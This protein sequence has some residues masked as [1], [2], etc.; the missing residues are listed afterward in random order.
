M[1]KRKRIEQNLWEWIDNVVS[2]VDIEFQEWCPLLPG[3]CDDFDYKAAP[4]MVVA[5][6]LGQRNILT[7]LIE[8]AE[9]IIGTDEEP[10]DE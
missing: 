4:D 8:D 9:N 7:R 5:Y 10:G 2:R 6:K 3:T 1:D